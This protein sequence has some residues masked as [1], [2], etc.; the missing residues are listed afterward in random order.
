MGKA[1][2]VV[3]IIF[4]VVGCL[5]LVLALAFGL[6]FYMVGNSMNAEQEKMNAEWESFEEQSI[7]T[8]GVIVEADG[9]TT[10]EYYVESENRYYQTT[11]SVSN[12]SYGVGNTLQVYYDKENPA[13]CMIPEIYESTYNILSTVFSGVGIG[14]GIAI[15]VFG[16]I[17]MVIGIVLLTLKPKVTAKQL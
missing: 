12:S 1:G 3:G 4:I 17:V 6:G 5:I 14:A 11:V 13:E 16:L 8:N 15:G 10:I 9:S 2:K 7:Q